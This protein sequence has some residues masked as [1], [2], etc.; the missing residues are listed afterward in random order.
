MLIGWSQVVSSNSSKSMIKTIEG[1]LRT[2]GSI[3]YSQYYSSCL[4]LPKKKIWKKKNFF[5]CLFLLKCLVLLI[6]SVCLVF[7]YHRVVTLPIFFFFIY[8]YVLLDCLMTNF[9]L[10][11]L[12]SVCC[13]TP[14]LGEKVSYDFTIVSM[15]VGKRVFTKTA[16]WIFLKLLM[17]LGCLKG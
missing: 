1:L 17:T 10:K 16:H 11:M 12:I 7:F 15:S 9:G 8:F 14:P 6:V 2:I 3:S 4:H 5:V 13:W